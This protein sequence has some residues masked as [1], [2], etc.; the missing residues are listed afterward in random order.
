MGSFSLFAV[1]Q[2]IAEFSLLFLAL[3]Y[4]SVNTQ[5]TLSICF[6]CRHLLAS[7]DTLLALLMNIEVVAVKGLDSG[8]R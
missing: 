8:I 5:M 6:H 1:S 7:C 2:G 4:F 3:Q